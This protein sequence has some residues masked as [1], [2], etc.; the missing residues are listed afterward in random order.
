MKPLRKVLLLLTLA[1]FTLNISPSVPT[2]DRTELYWLA[3]NI[4]HEAGNQPTLGKIAVG[5]VTINRKNSPLYAKSIEG[6]VKQRKQFSWYNKN[7]I[8]SPKQNAAWEESVAIANY[9]LTSAE[10]PVIMKSLRNATHFH[11]TYVRPQW[12]NSMIKVAQIGDHIF[13]RMKE[14]A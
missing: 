8:V 6:V 5:I 11:A 12:K 10:D 3:M 4:Y 13:Y 14:K 2:I 1:L 9:L 7:K